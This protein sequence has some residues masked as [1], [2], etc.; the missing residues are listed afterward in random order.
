MRDRAGPRIA[1]VGV[2]GSGKSTLE[3]KLKALGLE[4][5]SVAQEHSY[6][7]ELWR[8]KEP[9]LLVYLDANLSTIR[10]R[11]HATLSRLILEEERKR[12]AWARRKADLYIKTDRLTPEEVAGIVLDFLAKWSSGVVKRGG[13]GEYGGPSE[14]NLRIGGQGS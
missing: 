4:A 2:C 12:L 14:G 8:T 10:R 7:R 1:I 13:G 3:Q 5:F 6:V 9:H 11:G